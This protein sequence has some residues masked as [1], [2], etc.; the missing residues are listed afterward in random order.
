MPSR[1]RRRIALATVGGDRRRSRAA[2]GTDTKGCLCRRR[3]TRKAEAADRPKRSIRR[4]ERLGILRETTG[5]QRGRLYVYDAY[6]DILSRG[7][8]AN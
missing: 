5:K 1:S 3:C 7:T 2:S 6:L 4:L 8:E